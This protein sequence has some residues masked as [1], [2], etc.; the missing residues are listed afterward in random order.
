MTKTIL[1]ITPSTVD[2]TALA[3]AELPDAH[4]EAKQ[5]Y[6]DRLLADGNKLQQAT[7]TTGPF[8][9]INGEPTEPPEPDPDIWVGKWS[10]PSTTVEDDPRIELELFPPIGEYEIVDVSLDVVLNAYGLDNRWMDILACT[11]GVKGGWTNRDLLASLALRGQ[12]G[13]RPLDLKARAGMGTKMG[14]PETTNDDGEFIHKSKK[15]I[16]YD[17]QLGVTYRYVFSFNLSQPANRFGRI[18][19][20]QRDTNHKLRHQNLPADLKTVKFSDNHTLLIHLGA[21]PGESEGL[22]RATFSNLEVRMTP[23]A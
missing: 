1:L 18:T 8:E 16:A 15:I 5:V 9:P 22:T 10:G 3:H 12:S 2:N 21:T 14:D 13:M 4:P 23:K 19:P 11:R 7:A 20:T 6:I 17:F